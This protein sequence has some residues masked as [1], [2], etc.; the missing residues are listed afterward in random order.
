MGDAILKMA[1]ESGIWAALFCALFFIQIKDS[2]T[3]ETKYQQTIDTLAEKL[4]MIAEIKTDI[5]EIKKSV[6]KS[7]NTNT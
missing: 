7:D 1:S 2:K 6:V 5:E 4:K 3:R